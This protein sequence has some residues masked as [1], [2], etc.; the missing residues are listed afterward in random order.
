LR[1]PDFVVDSFDTSYGTRQPVAATVRRALRDVRMKFRVNGGPVRTVGVAEWDG[2]ERYGDTHHDYYAELRGT[3][4]GT[5]PGDQ[6]EVWFTGVSPAT[7]PV[8]STHFTYRVNDDIGADVLVLA[9][10]DV[11]GLSPVQS[12]TSARYADEVSAALTA[13]GHSSDVYDF[14]AMGREAPHH[15]GVLSHYRAVVWETGDD[16]GSNGV[17]PLTSGDRTALTTHLGNGGRLLLAGPD[18]IYLN[19]DSTFVREY[20][21]ATY[22][23]EGDGRTTLSGEPGRHSIIQAC[24]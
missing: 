7:G 9:A 2:G 20:L 6:V 5:A 18:A 14:D 16:F 10:E 11:T 24:A 15:L 8:A 17:A 13:A 12:G 23:R 4:T 19:E 3:V 22:L 1:T 21:H